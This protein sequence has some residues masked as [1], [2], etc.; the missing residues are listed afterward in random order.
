MPKL[1]PD[2]AAAA[3][4]F[5]TAMSEM[6]S[7]T[8]KDGRGDRPAEEEKPGQEMEPSKDTPNHD[9]VMY[10]LG[11]LEERMEGGF[12]EIQSRLDEAAPAEGGVSQPGN[13]PQKIQRVES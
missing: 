12:A 9:E 13:D 8:Y 5:S 1:T 11:A 7:G 4:S 10:A 3:L 2:E 6:L